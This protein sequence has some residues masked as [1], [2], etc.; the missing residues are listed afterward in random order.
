MHTSNLPDIFASLGI[1]VLVS[2]YQAGRL[3]MLRGQGDVLNTHFRLFDKPMGVAVQ[4]NRIA[5]G[6]GTSIW[7]FH[8]L[9]AVCAKVNQKEESG[10]NQHD[11][12]FLPRTTHWTGDIQI[13]EMAWVGDSTNPTQSELWFVNTRFS[14]LCRRSDTYCFDPVWRPSFV[15]SYVPTDVCHVNG[16]ATLDGRVSH[17]T[18]LGETNTAGG[19]RDN[20]RDGGILI[21]IASNE[22]VARG[23]SMPHSPRWYRGKLWLLESGTGSFGYVNLDTGKFESIATLGGFTRGL[24]FAGPLAFVGL[25]Q[26]RESAVFGGIPIA[27]RAIEERDCGVWVIN[28]ET[29]QTI[30]F[31]KFEDAVQE[32]FA[33]EVLPA[34]FPEL[35][36]EDRELLAGSFELPDHALQDVPAD[37]RSV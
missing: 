36:N 15:S 32:I 30:G 37:H 4:P 19:W 12:C 2:T 17:V 27:E 34:R 3:V 11:A 6:A 23:L 20:K 16:L 28:I 5:V 18:A 22:I 35:V 21:D 1:S 31:V 25:S 9:P 13:H 29:G 14:C 8:N 10:A 24:S 33:V 26:V 7:E